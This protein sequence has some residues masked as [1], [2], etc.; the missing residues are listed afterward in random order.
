[1]ADDQFAPPPA[2]AS[3]AHAAVVALSVAVL[4]LP[5][6]RGQFAGV[7]LSLLYAVVFGDRIYRDWRAGLLHMTPSEGAR[8]AQSSPAAV[9]TLEFAAALLG[10]VAIVV[11]I[12][13]R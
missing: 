3:A 1:M 6:L 10:C 5:E 9:T 8:R 2:W 12:S 4:L 13:R 7:T 11:L